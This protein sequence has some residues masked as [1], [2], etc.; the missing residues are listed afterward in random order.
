LGVALFARAVLAGLLLAAQGF[1]GGPDSGQPFSTEKMM[2]HLTHQLNLT[3]AQASQI[4][5]VL[6]SHQDQMT[7]QFSALKAARQ[8]LRQ[9]SQTNPVDE[10][11][12]RAAAQALGQA[13]GDHALLHAQI[14]SQILPF[15]SDEQKQKLATLDAAP[16]GHWGH[17][18]N[19]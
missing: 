14:R 16:P 18:S 6:D 11:A 19:D 1:A 12:I 15:L 8:A 4:K 5:Q 2:T 10:S 7:A 17:P 3:D 13:E 9:A